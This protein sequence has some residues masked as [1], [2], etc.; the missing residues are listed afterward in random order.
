MERRWKPLAITVLT[1]AMLLQWTGASAQTAD[2]AVTLHISQT[3]GLQIGDELLVSTRVRNNGPAVASNVYVD[4]GQAQWEVFLYE[5]VGSES[6]DCGDVFQ[7]DLDP[8][9]F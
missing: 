6:V 3:T 8:P 2:L 1:A 4:A 5:L 9:E 7:L